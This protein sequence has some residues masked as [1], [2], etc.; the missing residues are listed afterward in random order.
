MLTEDQLEN[1]LGGTRAETMELSI[2]LNKTLYGL[3]Y[4][5]LDINTADH[6]LY[7]KSDLENELAKFGVTAK[8]DVGKNGTGAGETANECYN[9]NGVKISHETMVKI[10]SGK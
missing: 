3:D 4:S 7:A 6:M 2:A 10:F 1:V 8:I 5:G 9:K